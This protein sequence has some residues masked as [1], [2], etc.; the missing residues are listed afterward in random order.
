MQ[1]FR[2]RLEEL[3]VFNVIP[4]GLSLE[5]FRDVKWMVDG[6]HA[7]LFIANMMTPAGPIKVVVKMLKKESVENPMARRE[8]D[9]E[10]SILSRVRSPNVVR[11]L[12]AGKAPRPFM[13]LEWLAKGT[14]SA[15]LA[16]N[17]SVSDFFRRPTFTRKALYAHARDLAQ[18][19]QFLHEDFNAEACIVHRGQSP[20]LVF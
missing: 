1:S 16:Q 6:S 9:M 17:Q 8:F 10:L 19:L 20:C 3:P 12:G 7:N 5:T 2:Y 4:V 18:C 15:Q 13:V 11:I 14:L